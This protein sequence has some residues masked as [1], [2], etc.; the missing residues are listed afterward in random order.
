MPTHKPVTFKLPFPLPPVIVQ[1]P[2]PL[3]KRHIK[4]FRATNEYV[5]KLIVG[6]ALIKEDRFIINQVRPG[7]LPEGFL[8]AGS[9]YEHSKEGFFIVVE[10]PSFPGHKPGTDIPLIDLEAMDI[11]V[12]RVTP[13][14]EELDKLTCESAK[15]ALAENEDFRAHITNLENDK[16]SL[17]LWLADIQ[18]LLADLGMGAEAPLLYCDLALKGAP[19]VKTPD[20]IAPLPNVEDE[21]PVES[22]LLK[23]VWKFK[24]NSNHH[25]ILKSTNLVSEMEMSAMDLFNLFRMIENAFGIAFNL[26]DV[27]TT[28]NFGELLVL[29]TAKLDEKP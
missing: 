18:G 5:A 15:E 28:V 22:R 11:E 16:Q 14:S 29:V 8:I 17:R 20:P 4:A 9:W 19:R 6:P 23:L 21:E 25:R 2:A 1:S 24:R 7:Q 3:A 10:H 12:E 27:G 13:A 26:S